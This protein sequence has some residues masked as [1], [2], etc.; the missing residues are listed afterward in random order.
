MLL[1]MLIN[2]SMPIVVAVDADGHESIVGD[3]AG[4]CKLFVC[5]HDALLVRNECHHIRS[6]QNEKQRYGK[7]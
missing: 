2:Q 3:V 1:S 7:L 6:G 4:D 5:V